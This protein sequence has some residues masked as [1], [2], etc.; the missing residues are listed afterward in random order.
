MVS[1]HRGFPKNF[2]FIDSEYVDTRKSA[3]NNNR[4]WA[5]RANNR[6]N[7][8]TTT[9]GVSDNGSNPH[10]N[11]LTKETFLEIV[12]SP[13]C[14]DSIETAIEPIVSRLEKR[15]SNLE[16]KLENKRTIVQRQSLEINKLKKDVTALTETSD[17]LQNTVYAQKR[18]ERMR[19]LRLAGISG[20]ENDIKEKCITLAK[21]KLKVD[22]KPEELTVR[23]SAKETAPAQL[24]FTNTWKR[25]MCFDKKTKLRGT[26][27][28]FI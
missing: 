8:E 10:I 28:F 11:Y 23:K 4:Q 16:T 3:K 17:D 24:L 5:L 2:V 1:Y 9:R 22:I 7:I 18:N 20:N 19:N 27:T 15:I 13:E 25:D 14:L 6:I 21:D 12:K 26:D